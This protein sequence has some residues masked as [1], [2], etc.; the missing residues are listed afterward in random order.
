MESSLVR[1]LNFF[2]LFKKRHNQELE[3]TL[4]YRF[5]NQG[6][7]ELAL[8]HR[9]YINAKNKVRI[10]SN[11]R[12]EFLG[13]AVLDLVITEYL[14]TSYVTKA[15]GHLSK[16]KSLVVS[17]KVL[18]KCARQWNLGEYL[19]LSLSEKKS[20]GRQRES[21]LADGYEAV[22]GAVYLDGG[23]S[24]AKKIVFHSLVP[25]ID[26]VLSDTA[27]IN[28][29]SE[30]LEYTQGLFKGKGTPEYRVL[31]ESGPEHKKKFK[32]GVYVLDALM[33]EG[34]GFSKKEAEQVAARDSL[35]KYAE[36]DASKEA[37]KDLTSE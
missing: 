21:I 16:I 37:L 1:I 32:V 3:N 7:L 12:L 34:M 18:A 26:D 14:Y 22:L 33:G 29:K 35:K 6:L 27:L 4:E 8:S 28:Y 36:A 10:D 23:L 24:K 15:E 30:L 11:E 5:H 19:L 9:S 25:I 20:G 2:N 31:E 13:D 17:S